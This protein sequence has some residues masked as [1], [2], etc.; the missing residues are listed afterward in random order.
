MRGSV[1]RDSVWRPTSQSV[2]RRTHIRCDFKASGGD[3]T[4]GNLPQVCRI[5]PAN[6]SISTS[7]TALCEPVA[8][9]KT[10]GRSRPFAV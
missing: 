2:D 8:R 5:R 10:G 1:S 7:T 3:C 6:H 9:S 4:E